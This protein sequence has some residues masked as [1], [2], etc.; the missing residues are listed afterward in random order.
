MGKILALDEGTTNV[1]A[2]LID[3]EGEMIS[4]SSREFRQIYPKSG[5]VEH[6]PEEI[7]KTQ[8]EVA[9]EVAKNEKIDVIGIT[10]QRETIVVWNKEGKPIYNAIVW[11]CR[12]T[13][14]LMEKVK[15]EYG[16]MIR[17]KTGL[18]ADAY[19]SASKIKWLLDQCIQ[20]HAFQHKK[21]R[22]GR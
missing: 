16:D 10:N 9:K 12:R 18:I 14:D 11:Q 15:K 5:W 17:E 2:S 7:W 8:V 3:D 4:S 19:F 1:K 21:G 20:N 13:A 22:M 6:S